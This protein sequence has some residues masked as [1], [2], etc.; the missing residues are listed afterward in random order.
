MPNAIPDPMPRVRS[1]LG[2][3]GACVALSAVAAGLLY[4]MVRKAQDS[5]RMSQLT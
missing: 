5:A 4:P 1:C 3:L 2:C